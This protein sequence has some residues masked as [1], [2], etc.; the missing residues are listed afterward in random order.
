MLRLVAEGY[1]S[2]GIAVMLWLGACRP[3]ILL[4][5]EIMMKKLRAMPRIIH[6][7]LTIAIT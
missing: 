7:L 4:Y 2:E 3:Y 6:R 5:R 1:S